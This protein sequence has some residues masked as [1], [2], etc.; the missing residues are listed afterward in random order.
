MTA[1]SITKLE[2]AVRA[3]ERFVFR[4]PNGGSQRLKNT[5]YDQPPGRVSNVLRRHRLAGDKGGELDTMR[6]RQ[7]H[8]L[9]RLHADG[10]CCRR[11]QGSATG[12]RR[13]DSRYLVCEA[14][15]KSNRA[16]SRSR[17]SRR[18]RCGEARLGRRAA[19]DRSRRSR[20]CSHESQSALIESSC[21]ARLV[22]FQEKN[23]FRGKNF[24]EHGER[25]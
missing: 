23:A 2:P 11:I 15:R 10:H 20:Y 21:T 5:S 14:C 16:D 13:F 3:G 24:S 17:R 25:S 22:V 4:S 7:S 9:M 6:F 19:N 12:W 18:Q 8:R 1:A